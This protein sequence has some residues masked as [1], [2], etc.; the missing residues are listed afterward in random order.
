MK[1]IKFLTALSLAAVLFS[2]CEKDEDN[3]VVENF[4]SLTVPASGY[5]NGA[6][7]S[8]GFKVN[9]IAFPVNYATY[10]GGSYWNGFGYSNLHD[11]K[12]RGYANQYSAY[13]L[14]DSSG[15]NTFV[16]AYLFDKNT[17]TFDT[18]VTNV[19]MKI[20]NSTYAALE[21]KY[22]DGEN[23]KK[24]GGSTGN[25]PD[26]F[27]LQ[28]IGI[29]EKN[30][31]TDTV[32]FYLADFTSTDNSKDYI[33]NEWK[34]VDL[35]KLKRIRKIKFELSSTDNNIYGMKTPAYFCLDDIKYSKTE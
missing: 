27:K 8:G 14:K 13:A 3:S 12:T 1:S 6:D 11:V 17:I 18:T 15:K 32:A 4:N 33:L 10:P 34:T 19:S 30:M 29:D 16:V 5:W 28:I 25:D 23:A 26:W 22:G 31:A 20:T 9:G 24:F 35:S 21:M 2:S 7:N